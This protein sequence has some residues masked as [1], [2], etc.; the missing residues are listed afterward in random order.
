MYAF[1][2]MRQYDSSSLQNSQCLNVQ[3]TMQKIEIKQIKHDNRGSDI[4]FSVLKI[5][6]LY[7]G[8]KPSFRL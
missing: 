6:Q 8:S 3:G 2:I 4:C 7:P 1:I 5:Y